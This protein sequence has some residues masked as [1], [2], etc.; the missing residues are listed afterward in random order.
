VHQ[1]Q[2][3][4]FK[5]YRAWNFV[6]DFFFGSLLILLAIIGCIVFYA[7]CVAVIE[8]F[9]KTLKDKWELL[10]F[11]AGSVWLYFNLRGISYIVYMIFKEIEKQVV[12]VESI[13]KERVST[14]RG[15]YSIWNA[16][17]KDGSFELDRSESEKI[18]VGQEVQLWFKPERKG[19]ARKNIALY[20]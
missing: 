1:K 4:K 3:K 20:V 19:N 18:Q 12:V 15:S 5:S 10:A 7:G 8:F 6:L 11:P 2:W 17:Y 13:E 9:A 16:Y 14:Q